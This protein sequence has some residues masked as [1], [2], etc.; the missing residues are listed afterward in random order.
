VGI[1]VSIEG[2]EC[3][4]DQIVR[5]ESRD[6][7]TYLFD[8]DILA[9]H[10]AATL[11]SDGVPENSFAGWPGQHEQVTNLM[12]RNICAEF[13][14]DRRDPVYRAGCH[15]DIYLRRELVSHAAGIDPTRARTNRTA[16]QDHDLAARAR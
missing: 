2:A 11:K 14:P 4:S 6:Q 7:A 15:P 5:T 1:Q 9:G 3:A 10:S 12:E 13:L 16:V 8:A